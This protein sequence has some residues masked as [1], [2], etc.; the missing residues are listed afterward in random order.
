MVDRRQIRS[1]EAETQTQ[2]PATRL[3]TSLKLLLCEMGS[4]PTPL[5]IKP[6][7]LDDRPARA[8]N[9]MH[10]EALGQGLLLTSEQS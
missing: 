2:P 10:T 6:I 7:T 1:P 8:E 9:Q 3:W 4:S 5:T